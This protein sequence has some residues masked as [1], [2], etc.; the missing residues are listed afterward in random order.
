M[1]EGTIS[2][3]G[4]EAIGHHGVYPD[5]RRNGQRFI[6]DVIL[7]LPITADDNLAQTVDYSELARAVI[8]LIEDDP[9]DLLETLAHRVADRCLEEPL[10]T[11]VTVIVHKPE[12]PLDMIFRDVTVTLRKDRGR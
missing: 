5:E 9:V 10:P 6:V 8:D 11:A 2:L 7:H 1:T 4:L 12:A 3:L